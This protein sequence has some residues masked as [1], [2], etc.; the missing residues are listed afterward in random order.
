MS[1]GLKWAAE[2]K[3]YRDEQTNVRVV[4]LTNYK[5]HSHH[6]Y[7]TN[8]GWFDNSQKLLFSSDRN[9]RCNLFSIDLP[10]G[11]ITQ[12]TDLEPLGYSPEIEPCRETEFMRACLNLP[13]NEVYFWRRCTL[14][15]LDLNDFTIR[16]LYEMPHE[17]WISMVNCTADGEYVCTGMNQ[18]MSHM[19]WYDIYR[20]YKGG[21]EYFKSRPLG[22]I[23]LIAVD[24]T[25]NKT[26]WEEQNFIN[27]INTS[28]T[29]PHLLT[30]C[31]EGSWAQVDH[32]IW[33]LDIETGHAWKIRL[34]K[35]DDE[36][37]T[38]EYWH[39]DG[40]YIGYHGERGKG[41]GQKPSEVIGIDGE[42]IGYHE[43]RN[44]EAGFFIGHIRYDNTDQCETVILQPPGHLHSNGKSF[45]VGDGGG[46]IR[47]WRWDGTE[48][49]GPRLL[50]RHDCTSKIQQLHVHPRLTPDDTKVLF[51]SDMSGYGNL[52]LADIPDFESLPELG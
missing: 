36:S 6:F 18:I 34:R 29:N 30:F 28:P 13:K 50:C 43:E 45:V 33:G 8:P 1:V 3:E 31:H 7:F 27:H 44:N 32:R 52:Y 42:Y 12:L 47:I 5:G 17:Y 51:T 16:P 40:E 15:A 9:N 4:Q 24:G 48:Y 14:V 23:E 11:E 10:T 26:I 20:N 19:P 21:A 41:T 49:C 22:R 37:I 38:H 46:V 39:A 35:Q 25:G 2:Q